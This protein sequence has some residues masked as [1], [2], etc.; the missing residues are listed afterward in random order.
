MSALGASLD[1]GAPP[2]RLLAGLLPDSEEYPLLRAELVRLNALGDDADERGR[3]PQLRANLER[4]RWLPRYLPLRRVEVRLAQF[5]L[6][7][8]RENAPSARH[9]VIVGAQRTPSPVFA[10]EI[11][12]VT[13]NPYWDPPASIAANE[14]LPRF[15]RNRAAA[16]REGFEAIDGSGRVIDDVDW[17]ARPFP[18]RLR[19]R[20]GEA[21]ALGRLRLDLP[22]PYAVYLH[23]TPNKRLFARDER[24]F[25]HGCIRVENPV[26]LAAALM[27]SPEWDEAE[28][29]AAIETGAS[30]AIALPAPVPI[31]VLYFTAVAQADGSIL[32]SNDL[33]RRDS[34][35]ATA[36]DRE[37]KTREAAL[38]H[39]RAVQFFKRRR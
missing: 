22:N 17:S 6:Y 11:V 21:N 14:L 33:Y 36:L 29:G 19:Q 1:A 37:G 32:Y 9:A 28:L 12:S 30:Q 18:Y 15:R 23:D 2:G 25:S 24:A 27:A 38:K 5:E 13:L 7:F 34:A 31:Y 10:A 3:I 20:P 26:A 39:E 35:I 8:H 16:R 4:W